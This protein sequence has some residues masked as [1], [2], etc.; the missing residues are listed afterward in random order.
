MRHS[1]L[2]PVIKSVAHYKEKV[3]QVLRG[4]EELKNIKPIMSGMGVY[5]QRLQGTFMLRVRI[6]AGVFRKQWMRSIYEIGKK[7][8]VARFHLT[9]REAIQFHDITLEQTIEVMEAL[10]EAGL[11]TT[12]AGGNWPRNVAATPLSGVEKE[13]VFDVTPYALGVGDYIMSIIDT[14]DLPRKYK[15]AFSSHEN[16]VVNAS[17]TDLGFI[18]QIKEGEKSFKVFVGGGIGKNPKTGIIFK[19]QVA[20]SELLYIV[21]GLKELFED[22][23]DRNNR[24][25]ARIRYIVERL[26]EE[27]FKETLQRYIDKVKARQELTLEVTPIVHDKLGEET[28]LIHKRL[29]L[30]KQ[31]GL[32]AI[33]VKPFGGYLS[34]EEL[35]ELVALVEAYEGTNVR[36]TMDQSLYITD[37]KGK[38]AEE[39]L[40][41]TESIGEKGI[42]EKVVACTGADTC[43][44]GITPSEQL[45]KHIKERFEE[46]PM[47]SYQALPHVH[48]SGCQNS[49]TAHQLARIGLMGGKKRIQDESRNVYTLFINGTRGHGGAELGERVGTLLM[50]S[51]PE[52]LYMLGKDLTS[53]SIVLNTAELLA[54]YNGLFI[55]E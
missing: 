44:I 32:Y 26:G 22:L 36:L 45:I 23:G 30:Q 38:E 13:E 15:I 52:F 54:T 1:E 11:V 37:L 35:G 50:E 27:V 46:V 16:D 48:I 51:V 43:Q 2:V 39:V 29:I 12:G 47:E 10:L 5:A 17:G 42:M 40:K 28:A 25:T 8:E 33:E 41:A 9:S 49:C 34:V 31:K 18:A 4:E 21:Q 7:V 55:E 6:P 20:P 53:G 3:S 14:F 19:E 24:N